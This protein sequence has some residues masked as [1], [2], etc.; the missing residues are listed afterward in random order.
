MKDKLIE[1]IKVSPL[2][3]GCDMDNIAEFIKKSPHRI[4]HK[5][6]GAYIARKGNDCT[7]L[8]MLVEGV[9]YG[10]MVNQD[11]KEI[12][13]ETHTG[14]AIL[15]PAF[16]FADVNKFPVNVVAQTACTILYIDRTTFLG[17]LH[18]DK[19]IMQNY[20]S[21]ISNRCQHLGRLLNDVALRSLKERVAEYLNLHKKIK[22]VERLA[23]VMG[24]ARPSLSRVLSELRAEGIIERTPDG[25]ELIVLNS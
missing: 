18:H 8:T 19:Q 23:R 3:K 22:S 4:R 5:D 10:S 11:G 14:P 9:A 20:L 25:I 6:E 13:V 1:K 2:F 24:V 21:M 7:D 15:A 12:I 16:L 17:W